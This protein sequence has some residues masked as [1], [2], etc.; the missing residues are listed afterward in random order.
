MIYGIDR[1]P[2]YPTLA[3]LS[4]EELAGIAE[5]VKAIGLKVEHYA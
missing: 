2:P 4:N 3:A 5:K 1:N